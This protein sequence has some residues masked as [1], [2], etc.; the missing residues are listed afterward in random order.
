MW[1]DGRRKEGGIGYGGDS[2]KNVGCMWGESGSPDKDRRAFDEFFPEILPELF[3]RFLFVVDS[4]HEE[5][6]V[7]YPPIPVCVTSVV[8]T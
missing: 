8:L 7:V 5:V 3:G 4:F 6:C 2:G 1:P